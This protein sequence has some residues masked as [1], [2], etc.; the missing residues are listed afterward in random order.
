VPAIVAGG[1][2]LGLAAAGL[3]FLLGN[4]DG[5]DDPTPSAPASAS[6]TTAP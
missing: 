3:F 2:A 6:P 5:D 1:V 4:D